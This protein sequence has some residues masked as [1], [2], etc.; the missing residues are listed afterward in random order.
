MR[1]MLRCS[2]DVTAANNAFK[3]GSAPA[4]LEKLMVLTKPEAAYF[5][6][7]GGTRTIYIFFDM[8]DPSEMPSIGEL[9]W[10]GFGGKV[11]VQPVMNHDELQRGLAL[12]SEK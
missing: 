1:T 10:N 11:E 4:L 12:I 2:F 6:A 9:M 3:N 7:D 5:T 8:K